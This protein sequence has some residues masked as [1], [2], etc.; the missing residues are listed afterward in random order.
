MLVCGGII[1]VA[2]AILGSVGSSSDGRRSFHT[3]L[4][5]ILWVFSSYWRRSWSERNFES[6]VSLL[7]G[8]PSWSESSFMLCHAPSFMAAKNLSMLKARAGIIP[9]W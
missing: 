3:S 8:S 1:N 5:F 4:I 6:L 2:T 7:G 9:A